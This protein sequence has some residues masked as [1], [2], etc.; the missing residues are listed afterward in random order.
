MGISPGQVLVAKDL[1][2]KRRNVAKE[3]GLGE[4]V[5][6]ARKKRGGT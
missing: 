6:K 4:R 5:G 1:S 2:A 3:K